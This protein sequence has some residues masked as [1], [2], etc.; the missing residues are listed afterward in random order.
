MSKTKN[1]HSVAIVYKHYVS[2][3]TGEKKR[4]IVGFLFSR[5]EENGVDIQLDKAGYEIVAL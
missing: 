5:D 1:K 4:C 2:K 3:T